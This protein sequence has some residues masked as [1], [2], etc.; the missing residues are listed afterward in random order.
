MSPTA[1]QTSRRASAAAAQPPC[2][3]ACAGSAGLGVAV[4]AASLVM[5]DAALG[6]TCTIDVLLHAPMFPRPAPCLFQAFYSVNLCPTNCVMS[7]FPALNSQQQKT[8]FKIKKKT[9]DK[10][11]SSVTLFP[12]ALS[13]FIRL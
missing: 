8:L 9:F 2:W 4:F 13:F 3:A 12:L 10:Y 7:R 1:F 5:A 6:A 11:S